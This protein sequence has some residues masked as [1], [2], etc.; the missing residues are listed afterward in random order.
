MKVILSAVLLMLCSMG[1]NAELPLPVVKA[2]LA[3]GV[4]LD[5][6]SAHVQQLDMQGDLKPP[7]VSY[8]ADQPMNPASTMKLLTA[9]AALEL[10]GPAYRWPTQFYAVSAPKS[11][12]ISGDLWVKGSGDPGLDTDHLR[13]VVQILRQK[14]FHAICCNLVLDDSAIAASVF[15]AGAFDGQALRVYNAPAESLMVNQQAVRLHLLPDAGKVRVITYPAWQDLVV[16]S[17]MTLQKGVCGDWKNAIQMEVGNSIA[18]MTLT[19]R[20]PYQESCGEKFLDVSLLPDSKYFVSLFRT[21]WLDAGG[22]W[23]SEAK[24]VS[25]KRH[26]HKKTADNA[27]LNVRFERIPQDALLLA[28]HQSEPL[29]DLV[30]EMNKTSNNVMARSLFL[31]LGRVANP[32]LPAT[33]ENSMVAVK[34]WLNGKGLQFPELVMENGAGLSRI[35]RISAQHLGQLLQL[36]FASPVMPELMSS[37]PVIGVDGTLERRKDS[38][39]SG[40]AHLK[41]GSIDGVRSI[42]GY[43]LDQKGRRWVVVFMVNHQ[44][45]GMSKV[46][47]EALLDWVYQQ[48]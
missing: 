43:V 13:E 10:L 27:R 7:L 33:P 22:E 23:F 1:A 9:Y 47:Q 37:L 20:G 29:A 39:L 38:P 26:R 42:A 17:E 45:A 2:L 44:K 48:P 32:D 18:P 30:R 15:D 8:R 35:E 40:R 6:V 12:V 24:S 36:G 31:T 14:G 41:T 34:N 4:P 28:E 46:A 19:L 25:K 21:L 5:S 16:I 11:G 3:E